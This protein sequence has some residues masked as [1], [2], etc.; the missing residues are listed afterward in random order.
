MVPSKKSR[1]KIMNKGLGKGLEA[2]FSD[3]STEYERATSKSSGKITNE[4]DIK[5]VYPNK[6]QPRKHFDAEAIH[7]LAESIRNHGIISPL[8]VSKEDDGYMIVAGERRWRA[9]CI[10]G[11]DTVP[12]II[13]EYTEKT[14]A[15]I[16]LVENLQRENLNVVETAK[17]IA[18]LMLKYSLTQ[19]EISARLG[20]SRSSVANILRILQLPGVVV[21][22][23]AEGSLSFGHGR[24]LA[25]L[26][27]QA[28]CEKMALE[29]IQKG[30]SVRELERRVAII[31]KLK[32]D[33]EKK[34]E[35]AIADY[36][37]DAHLSDFK[38]KLERKLATKVQINGDTEKGK[39]V[40][41]YFSSDDL[42][43]YYE[44]LLK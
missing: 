25:V 21:S 22:L 2:L 41:E 14:I 5:K 43:R 23:I 34:K 12:V 33:A 42:E 20:K 31:Q 4:V 19:E 13:K 24:A 39:I 1:G 26:E 15:E 17:G 16:A 38:T 30:Y 6:N 44:I 36:N 9:A 8:I 7:G 35:K 40:I 37:R 11:L 27:D 29:T 3:T 32:G 28:M 10:A 18:E